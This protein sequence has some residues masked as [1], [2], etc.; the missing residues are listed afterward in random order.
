MHPDIRGLQSSGLGGVPQCG[1]HGSTEIGIWQ[2]RSELSLTLRLGRGNEA[3][4]LLIR[5]NTERPDSWLG[6]RY[7]IGERQDRGPGTTRNR[8][9]RCSLRRRQRAQNKTVA[10]CDRCLSCHGGAGGRPG[11]I[12]DIQS[13]A[14]VVP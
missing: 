4:N 12:Q 11:G 6:L 2:E 5:R 9:D 3:S 8:R 7:I 1:G 10:L 13:R 14:G